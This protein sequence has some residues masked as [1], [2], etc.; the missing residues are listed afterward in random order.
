MTQSW[1]PLF[2]GVLLPMFSFFLLKHKP[3][4]LFLFLVWGC[5]ESHSR[6]PLAN[7]SEGAS[8][9]CP[10]AAL[11]WEEGCW[12]GILVPWK[13]ENSIQ[14]VMRKQPTLVL[15]PVCSSLLLPLPQ[16]DQNQVAMELLSA[17]LLIFSPWYCQSGA[18]LGENHQGC[19]KL[20]AGAVR[21]LERQI[22]GGY[23]TRVG[24][25]VLVSVLL[26]S[27]VFCFSDDL[28]T[29][30]F[31][32]TNCSGSIILY[33][34]QGSFHLRLWE[35]LSASRLVIERRNITTLMRLQGVK[36]RPLGGSC[37]EDSG[38]T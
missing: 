12:D 31:S 21:S 30:S 17:E 24:T 34:L 1:K 6:D 10:L 27:A 2:S 36:T 20:G 19:E 37:E 35:I 26:L 23:Y 22:L 33:E 29:L 25:W 7:R 28:P 4:Q 9:S 16:A 5:G 8:E 32:F 18:S 15:M 11:P 13:E 3:N 38:F 14:A